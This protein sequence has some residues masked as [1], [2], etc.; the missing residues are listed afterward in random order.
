MAAGERRIGEARGRRG[1]EGRRERRGR[2]VGE[3]RRG[4]NQQADE[5]RGL[6]GS[7]GT[8]RSRRLRPGHAWEGMRRRGGGG[9]Q[10]GEAATSRPRPR[11]KQQRRRAARRWTTSPRCLSGSCASSG[12]LARTRRRFSA[13]GLSASGG[14]ARAAVRSWQTRSRHPLLPPRRTA[15]RRRRHLLPLRRLV[16]LLLRW[17]LRLSPRRPLRRPR[18]S[19]RRRPRRPLQ[20]PPPTAPSPTSCRPIGLSRSAAPR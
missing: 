5:V 16:R 15:R 11:E 2:E 1:G 3:E 7:G 6:D 18:R 14:S 10:R 12:W 13:S 4:G 20:R 9:G 19:R 17:P 8:E